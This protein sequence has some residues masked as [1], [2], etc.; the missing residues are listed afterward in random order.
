MAAKIRIMKFET[1]IS[2]SKGAQDWVLIAPLGEA[3]E[4]TQTWHRVK[5]LMPPAEASE[6]VKDSAWF[7]DLEEKWEVIGPAYEQFSKGNE[8]PE[9]GT[10][11]VTWSAVTPEQVDV[12]KKYGITT[13]ELA[14]EMSESTV[15]KLHWPSSR[16]L[17]ELAKAWLDGKDKV[18]T[19]KALSEANERIRVMEEMLREMQEA[20]PEK[21]GPGRP[22]KTEAA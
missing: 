9:T 20:Q 17:P 14:A 12:L 21:R 10:P 19:D 6:T 22:R 2:E 18:E 7:K 4:R 13:V 1:R 8:I 15:Q 11:I 5:S 16:K 3:V